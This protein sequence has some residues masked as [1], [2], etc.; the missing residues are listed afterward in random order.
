MLRTEPHEVG[1]LLAEGMKVGVS[2]AV[3]GREALQ[4]LDAN[5]RLSSMCSKSLVGV[6][7]A[8]IVFTTPLSTLTLWLFFLPT[9]HLHIYSRT[10]NSPTSFTM[11]E[12]LHQHPAS[13]W[14]IVESESRPNVGLLFLLGV[15]IAVSWALWWLWRFVLTPRLFPLEVR[16][17]PY[18]IPSKT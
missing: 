5:I 13:V 10:L 8:Y 9:Q 12:N 15:S 2:S 14:H 6:Q 11:P 4:Y 16:E 3:E 18:W 17:Y 1:S 7:K